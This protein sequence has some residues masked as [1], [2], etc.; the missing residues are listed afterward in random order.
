MIFIIIEEMLIFIER[1]RYVHVHVH[2]P[3]V[4][5]NIRSVLVIGGRIKLHIYQLIRIQVKYHI[6][7]LCNKHIIHVHVYSTCTGTCNTQL[8]FII[9]II[10][11]CI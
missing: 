9:D 1:L 10:I 2:V 5:C 8:I 4:R 3:E 11:T 6:G 7:T